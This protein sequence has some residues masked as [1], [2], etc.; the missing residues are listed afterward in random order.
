MKEN[1]ADYESK[2]IRGSHRHEYI[3]IKQ[4]Y[5]IITV[6]EKVRPKY[7]LQKQII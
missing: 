2:V 3:I 6:N 1:K 7:K 4:I 5:S